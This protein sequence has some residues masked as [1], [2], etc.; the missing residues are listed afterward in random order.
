MRSLMPKKAY[1]DSLA[2]KIVRARGRCQ[3]PN[4]KTPI[5]G[6]NILVWSHI[7]PRKHLSLRW[8]T[9][10]ALCLCFNCERYFTDH[11]IEQKELFISVIGEEKYAELKFRSHQLI[12]VDYGKVRYDLNQEMKKLRK[13]GKI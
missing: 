12:K 1:L 2:G 3:N 5:S 11:P 4:C 13:M 7:M 10:N 8:D 9:T 6:F